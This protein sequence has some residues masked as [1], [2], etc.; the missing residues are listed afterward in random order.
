MKLIKSNNKTYLHISRGEWEMIGRAFEYKSKLKQAHNTNLIKEAAGSDG[1]IDYETF[2]QRMID[3]G[4]IPEKTGHTIKWQFNKLDKDKVNHHYMVNPG[5]KFGPQDWDD[6]RIWSKIKGDFRKQG[7]ST[8]VDILFSK[9]FK[10]PPDFDFVT[11][12]RKGEKAPKP[13]MYD[14]I[15]VTL[16]QLW[17]LLQDKSSK[18]QYEIVR[19]NPESQQMEKMYEDIAEVDVPEKAIMT[20]DGSLQIIPSNVDKVNVRKEI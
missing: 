20:A 12:M 5:I 8:F 11:L 13:P 3:T 7:L 6:K 16:G 1:Y 17:N 2:Q 4:W 19:F 9:N 15:K 10:F 18:Y 14:F